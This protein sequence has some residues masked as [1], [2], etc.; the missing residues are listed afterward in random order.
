MMTIQKILGENGPMAEV[1]T[2]GACP[3]VIATD[4]GNAYI[5]GYIPGREASDAITLPEGEAIVRIPLATLKK[6]AAQ[7]PSL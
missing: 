3:A 2:G 4:D 1:C 5:Q 7:L 6:L